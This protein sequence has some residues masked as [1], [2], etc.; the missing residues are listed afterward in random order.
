MPISLYFIEWDAYHSMACQAAPC[1]HPGSQPA[2]P[3]PLKQNVCTKPLH[4]QAGPSAPFLTLT[5]LWILLSCSQIIVTS[6]ELIFTPEE[7][8][9]HGE[10]GRAQKEKAAT[11][12]TPSWARGERKEHSWARTQVVFISLVVSPGTASWIRSPVRFRPFSVP[13][14]HNTRE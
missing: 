7:S 2:N 10:R 1:P 5:W 13:Q 3:R 9:D 8:S 6:A 4:H 11:T 12:T 14:S